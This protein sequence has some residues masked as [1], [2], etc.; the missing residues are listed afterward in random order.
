MEVID[1]RELGKKS[2]C[3]TAKHQRIGHEADPAR[4]VQAK[5][6]LIDQWLILMVQEN[7]V[8]T[9]FGKDGWVPATVGGAL[10]PALY[11]LSEILKELLLNSGRRWRHGRRQCNGDATSQAT[12]VGEERTGGIDRGNLGS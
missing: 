10:K 6:A 3:R 12:L 4:L 2:A 5:T 1:V 9:L 8:E 7:C 11:K